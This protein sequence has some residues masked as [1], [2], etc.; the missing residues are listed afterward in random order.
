VWTALREIRLPEPLTLGEA[1][2]R[3]DWAVRAIWESYTGWFH[4]SST[5]ELYG[6]APTLGAHEIVELA[7]GAGAVARRAT[8]LASTDPLTAVRLCDLAL[9]AVP[10]HRGAL[11]AYRLAHETLLAEHAREN[12]WLTRWLEGEI[13]GATNRLGRLDEP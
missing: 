7:G 8:T 11:E 10:D 3:V 5:L 13:R 12:F 1:Y 2:G 9:A 6:A 4:Q